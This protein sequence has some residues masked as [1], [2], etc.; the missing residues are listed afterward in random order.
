MIKF[1]TVITTILSAFNQK[2]SFL[3]RPLSES[4]LSRYLYVTLDIDFT[5]TS[6]TRRAKL[7]EK[8]DLFIYEGDNSD[9]LIDSVYF[10]DCFYIVINL[11]LLKDCG[12]S[13]VL[14]KRLHLIY[15]FIADLNEKELNQ[16]SSVYDI[17]KYSPWILVCLSAHDLLSDFTYSE[18]S[19]VYDVSEDFWFA[20]VRSEKPLEYLLPLGQK[21]KGNVKYKE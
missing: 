17:N 8:Y 7:N 21:Y 1:E 6:I 18:I 9:P 14:C 4:D 13:G 20:L 5:K 16:N 10:Q 15:T 3:S 19:E 12:S 2:H 11:S